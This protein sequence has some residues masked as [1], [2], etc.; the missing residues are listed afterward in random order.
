MAIHTVEHIQERDGDYF[1]SGSRVTLG[2]AIA[3]WLQGGERPESITEAF[4]SITRADAYGAI[5]FYLDHRQELD[6]FFAEQEYEFER[7]RAESQAADPGF[8]EQMRRRIAA[9][10]DSGWQRHEELATT[11]NTVPQAPGSERSDT[12]SSGER[13]EENNNL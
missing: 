11:D 4:P 6:R 1:V 5:A 7:Q 13:A 9:L 10:R 3:A 2:S 12:D 8:Y